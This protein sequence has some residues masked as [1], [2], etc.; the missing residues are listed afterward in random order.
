LQPEFVLY[1]DENTPDLLYNGIKFKD[2][3]YVTLRL[4]RNNTRLIS[5]SLANISQHLLTLETGSLRDDVKVVGEFGLT[6]NKG[7]DESSVGGPE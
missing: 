3:P 1:P 7:F 4:H 6:C 5:R 2:L